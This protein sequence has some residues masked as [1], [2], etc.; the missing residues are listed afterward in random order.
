M[1]KIEADD[2]FKEIK[3]S[4]PRVQKYENR[5]LQIEKERE[6]LLMIEREAKERRGM[7]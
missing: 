1:K 6:A 7:M 3:S 5:K 2:K 4:N